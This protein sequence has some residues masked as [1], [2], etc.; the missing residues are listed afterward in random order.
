[1]ASVSKSGYY[2]YLR[3]LKY[4]SDKEYQEQMDFKYIKAAYEYK[5]WKKGAVQIKMR[6]QRDYGIT[7][8][9]KRIR[10]IMRKYKLICPIR[11]INPV[12]AML[13]ANQ[14]HKTYSNVLN[15]NF[16]QGV[17]KKTVL[18]DI[19][20]LTYGNGKRAYLSVMKDSST[21]MILACEISLTLE[22]KFV[23]ETVNQLLDN[24]KKE[25]DMNV[26]KGLI[27]EAFRI[28]NY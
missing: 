20:Y 28:N 22:L 27:I 2:G 10:R 13:K 24:Y 21:N 11:K 17:A 8:N 19:T 15:R 12:K 1:M 26:I 9:L 5:S 7:M 25:L 3:R 16:T 23:I 14:S 6:I 18:T 4:P